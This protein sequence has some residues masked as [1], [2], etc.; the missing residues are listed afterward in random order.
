MTKKTGQTVLELVDNPNKPPP[1]K[2]GGGSGS[3]GS[4]SGQI[5]KKQ[6]GDYAIFGGAFF[7]IKAGR[8]G[9][10]GTGEI[11]IQLCNFTCRI[12]EEITQDDGLTDQTMLRVEGRRMD[13]LPLPPV[14]VPA[15]KFFS[16]QTNWV[17]EFY[18]TLAF[19]FPGPA[20]RDNLRACIQLYSTLAGDVPKRHIY[21]YTGW[22]QI[23]GQWCYLTGSGAIT[24]DGLRDDIQV[25][26]GGGHMSRYRL[27]GPMAGDAIKEA[28]GLITTLLNICP[29]KPQIGAALLAAV[30]RAPLGEC[31]PIDFC[32]FIHGITGAK[33][34]AIT[35]IALAFFGDFNARR[36]PANFSD[37]DN[38]LE[39]KAHQAKDGVFVVDDYKP[40]VSLAEASKLHAKAERLI[41]NTGNQAGRGRRDNNMNAKTAPYNRS[42]TI[43]T[44][45]DLPRG[46]SLIGRL[47][48][49]ELTRADVDCMTLTQ[50]QQA[51]TTG[52]LAGLMAAYLQWLASRLDRLR[53]ELPDIVMSLRTGADRDGYATSH[54]RAPELFANLVAGFDVF[55]DFLES[56]GVIDGE[57]ARALQRAV[58]SGLLAAFGE[59]NAY[60][61]EQD[62]VGRFFDLL[63]ALMISGNAHIADRL[64]QGP[65]PSR[66]HAFGWRAINDPISGPEHRPMGNCVGWYDH[67]TRELWLNQGSAYAEIQCLARR[68]GES[69][70]MAAETLWR[71]IHDRG[72]ITKTENDAQRSRPRLTIK[73][74]IAGTVQR[75]M[76]V[77]ADLIDE[78]P[79]Y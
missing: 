58:E 16:T 41:R 44:G 77:S 25:D 1:P 61:A 28:A 72:L 36:F 55:T 35:A 43:I 14:D 34:S 21:K 47:L 32:L 57:Q 76:I 42:M 54:S 11:E 19:V 70:L 74:T 4:G 23:D 46:P 68:Q 53:Q 78:P 10:D 18:G 31:H 49:L 38:D 20:K 3:S 12:I 63:R 48:I 30:A 60:Q 17:N 64:N 52:R 75:V 9:T 29:A 24:A 66:P 7:Q 39:F 45:E 67:L 79:S 73:K 50:L 5:T 27:P 59:Q 2:T 15:T 37:T 22:K 71:R 26:M 56:A 13:G 40:S 8:A 33:K 6:F 65:P 69:F 62:E 51:A